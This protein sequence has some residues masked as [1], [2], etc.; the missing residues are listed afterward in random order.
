MEYRVE[1][2]EKE[3]GK[4]PVVDF[5]QGLEVKKQAKVAREIDLLEKFGSELHY[6]HVDSIKGEKYKGLLEL[7]IEFA[8]NIFRIFFFLPSINN[9]ILLHGIVKK[10]QKTP[11]KELDV[12]LERM[13]DYLRRKKDGME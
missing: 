4:M 11:K 3:G 8:S 1:M 9:A 13:K 12:A 6:P 5:I 10:K 2:Y 7:R